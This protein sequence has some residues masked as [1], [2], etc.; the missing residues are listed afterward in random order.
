MQSVIQGDNRRFSF[1]VGLFAMAVSVVMTAF[2]PPAAAAS[3]S[4]YAIS[5]AGVVSV[6]PDQQQLYIVSPMCAPRLIMTNTNGTTTIQ[7]LNTYLNVYPTLGVSACV[8]VV[9][10]PPNTL[11]NVATYSWWTPNGDVP[12][13]LMLPVTLTNIHTTPA[14]KAIDITWDQPA[15][16][17]WVDHYDFYAWRTSD[18]RSLYS[19]VGV[20]SLSSFRMSVPIN[21]DD[22]NVRIVPVNIFGQGARTEF[23]ASANVTP[24]AP[25]RVSLFPGDHQLRVLFAPTTPDEAAISTYN[26][27][28]NPGNISMQLGAHQTDVTLSEGIV[29]NVTYQ[30]SVTATNSAGTSNPADSNLAT[31]RA[32]PTPVKNVHAFAS[33]PRGAMVN[34]D[35]TSQIVT[36]YIVTTST[37]LRTEVSANHNSATF[38]DVLSST[39]QGRT[40]DFSV[41]PVNDYLIGAASTTSTTLT[42]NSP[43]SVNL[44]SGFKAV[45]ANWSTPINL[46]TPA[47]SYDVELIGPNN[48]VVAYASTSGAETELTFGGLV[49]GQRLRAQVRI[50]TAWGSSAYSPLSATALVEDVPNSPEAAL[51]TQLKE[52]TP[53][54]LVTLGTVNSRGCALTTWNVVASWTDSLGA[55]QHAEAT[56]SAHNATQAITG[57]NFGDDVTFMITATNCWGDSAAARFTLH[58]TAPPQPVTNA[59]ASLNSQGQVVVTWTPSESQSVTSVAVT[60]APIGKVVTVSN[61]TR[62]VVFASAALGQTYSATLVAKNSFGG[63]QS[64]T[65]NSVF[66][67]VLPS[68]VDNLLASIDASNA[69]A[70][71]D[72]QE[73]AFTGYPIDGYLVTVDDH[74]PETITQTSVTI[75]GLLPGESHIISVQAINAMGIGPASSTTFGLPATPIATPDPTGTVIVWDL[76]S[77]VTTNSVVQIQQRISKSAPWRTIATV[78]AGSKKLV[79]KKPAKSAQYRVI[80]RTRGRTVVVKSRKQK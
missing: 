60:L 44:S 45:T 37:G 51:V 73:P 23:A 16:A 46:D 36:K 56:T 69:S 7:N 17:K 30:A 41:L 8:T 64:V 54:A 18:S 39:T 75:T 67:A 25:A 68:A 3:W 20:R 52:S 50:N 10:F 11:Q 29:N 80:T 34:W 22:W 48:A 2:A 71:I 66:S 55:L 38:S 74:S 76:N 61:T 42:P 78:R 4:D 35:V 32:L 47:L 43:E 77:T 62:R 6:Q 1:F 13:E 79:L 28:I 12:A 5:N 26:L 33:G 14:N 40:I 65:T 15:L 21:S 63:S 70:T 53:T 49:S 72:W 57:F 27:T 58:I 9:T 31:T 59:S 19:A 24:K